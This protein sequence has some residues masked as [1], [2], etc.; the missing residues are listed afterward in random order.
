ME[1]WRE[2]QNIG[3]R[4]KAVELRIASIDSVA[5]SI[6]PE[7]LADFMKQNPEVMFTISTNT[8]EQCYRYIQENIA[9]IAL[10]TGIRNSKNVKV[11]PAYTEPFVF[12]CGKGSDY[13]EEIT[14]DYLRLSDNVYYWHGKEVDSW[15]RKWFHSDNKFSV[16]LN[17]IS[18]LQCYMFT[19]NKW[20]LVPL[21]N[22]EKTFK[23]FECETR[24][25]NDIPSDRCIYYVT[26]INNQESSKLIARFLAC[27]KKHLEKEEKIR[28]FIIL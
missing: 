1:L 26:N 14:V 28:D 18:L 2:A 11:V 17:K 21:M 4:T 10:V 23:E 7:I 22:C 24:K 12:I 15:Y 16:K 6:L 20:A 19:A 3:N 25:L 13:P 5:T 8:E 9:D 27:C